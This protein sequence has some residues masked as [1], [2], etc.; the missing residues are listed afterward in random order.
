[1]KKINKVLSFLLILTFLLTGFPSELK[2]FAAPEDI[3]LTVEY[4]PAA[5]KY[6]I[7]YPISTKPARVVVKFHTADNVLVEETF[8]DDMIGFSAGKASISI[9]EKLF[10]EDR[11]EDHIYDISLEAYRRIEDTTPSHK[12]EVYYLAGMTFEGESF[13]QMAKSSYIEDSKPEPVTE[14]GSETGNVVILKSGYKPVIKLTWNVPTVIV[15]GNKKILTDPDTLAALSKNETISTISFHINMAK[16][17]GNRNKVQYEMNFTAE[18][19]QDDDAYKIMVGENEAEVD[20][21]SENNKM[22][23]TLTED[24]GIEPGTEYEFT[25]IGIVFKDADSVEI[26]LNMTKFRANSSNHFPVVNKDNAFIGMSQNPTSI[27]TPIPFEI[28]KIDT[29]KVEVRFR[30]IKYG[31]YPE[32]YYQVQYAPTINDLTDTKGQWVKIPASALPSGDYGYEI[33]NIDVTGNENPN[34]YFRV[35]CYDSSS[36]LPRSSSL[37]VNLKDLGFES[38]RPPMPKE[39]KVIP[40]YGGRAKVTVPPTHLSS[41]EFQIPV[42]NLQI[43][44]EKPISWRQHFNDAAKD[45]TG[46]D[47]FKILDNDDSDY[48]FH[49]ILSS[50]L[51]ESKVEDE[52]KVVQGFSDSNAAISKEVYLPVKQK[53][54]LVLSK[55]DFDQDPDDPNKI[56][57]QIPGDN[58]FYDYASDEELTSE[59]NEDPSKDGTPGDYPTFLVPNT[60]YYMQ[61]F[62]SRYGDLDAINQ[63]VWGDSDKLEGL[64]EKISYMSPI[65]SFTTYPLTEAAVPLPDIG[66]LEPEIIQD[67][68]TGEIQLGIKVDVPRI[69]T[70]A[71]WL[72][73]TDLDKERMVMYEFF[74]SR[75]PEDLDS[76]TTADKYYADIYTSE[77]VGGSVPVSIS[78]II[79]P[80]GTKEPILPNTVYYIKAR[81]SLWVIYGEPDHENPDTGDPKDERLGGSMFTAIKSV[82]MPKIDVGDIDDSERNPRAP[83]SFNIAIDENGEQRVGDAWVYL[84][85]N[86]NEKDVTYE[87][88]CTTV[89]IP[90]YDPDGDEEPVYVNDP[91][92]QNFLKA[93]KEFWIPKSVSRL[94][95]DINDPE[96][97]NLG[98]T[99]DENNLVVM[100]VNKEFLRPNRIYY[101]SLRA[102]RNR[103]KENE[104]ISRWITVPVTTKMVQAPAFL[105]VVKDME[106]GFNI[107]CDVPGTTADSMEVSIKKKDEGST[108]YIKLNRGNYT[109]VQD[110]TT[111]YFRIYNLEPNQWY[112]ILVKNTRNKTWYDANTRSW[113]ASEGTPVQEKTLNPLTEIEVRFEGEE[114]YTYLLEARTENDS[115]YQ[116]LT[117]SKTGNTDYGYDT[118]AGREEFYKEKTRIFVDE[119]S[120]KYIYYARI[121]GISYRDD[122]G[123]L[124][125]YQPLKSNTLYYIK[126]FKRIII[127]D[128]DGGEQNADSLRVGPVTARTDFSQS[129]YDKDKDKDN[130][131]DLFNDTADRLIRKLYWR[132][133]IKTGASVR[134]L[135]K[136]DRIAGLLRA[137]K[138][139]TIT[140]DISGEQADTSY[141]EILIPYKTLEA[142]DTFDSR[143]NI[144]LL[145]AEITINKGSIDLAALKKQVLTG[146]TKE[147]MLLLKVNRRQSPSNALSGGLAA[148]SRS[149]GLQAVAVGSRLSYAEIDEMI[150][151]ILKKPDAKGPFKYGILDRELTKVLKNLESYS[152]KSHVDLKDL[153]NSVINE[154]EVELSRY[155]KDIIDGGSGLPADFVVTKSV[156]EF[157]GKIGVKIEYSYQ[158]GYISPYVNYG[159]GWK[160]PEGGKGYV[161]QYVLFRAE[162]PGEYIVAVKRTS[163]QQPG[164]V[165]DNSALSFLSSRYDLTKVFGNGTIYTANPIKGEQAVMLY[166]VVT[167]RDMEITGL[168]PMQKVTKLDLGGIIGSNEITGYMNNQASVSLAV[169]LYCTKMNIDPKYMRPSK[170][171]TITNSSEI[172]PRLYPYVVLGVDLNLV[173]LNNRRFDANGRTTIGSMLDMVAKVLEGM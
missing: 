1:M 59:N 48:V 83:S 150:F 109:C 126:V 64:E 11:I 29:D 164:T 34:M 166:A 58:L 120:S 19:D 173:S 144:K 32:L 31:T 24:H 115:K 142:I 65:V 153:I 97:Q 81:A 127:S 16:G 28:T 140:V 123:N 107:A 12:G 71:D 67:P 119:G 23:V 6:K 8:T 168:T 50:Y 149:Y 108:S 20:F 66:L 68:D 99:T 133:D 148:A 169:K 27:F 2:I 3:T 7:S 102:V 53:R 139:S 9:D 146:G 131:T 30:K 154:V 160:S 152:Y 128:P 76:K 60:T 44:M 114:L 141:Y 52:T 155:L 158:N 106:I 125:Y 36:E 163:G 92:N 165:P 47:S 56:T 70:N 49:I 5:Y 156:N 95:L 111:F 37:A 147:A 40:V 82:T 45:I 135:L 41:G 73:Y 43:S 4:D 167:E 79:T 101:F 116:E 112:D 46:W 88:V 74:V 85:W 130:T 121:R 75:S 143:L 78:E 51:P 25:N 98:L 151:N 94:H 122:G 17:K 110:G 129:D 132:I 39:I 89:P 54:V 136:D 69:L 171:I 93:Y 104:T 84:S 72:R 90:E 170:T 21:D 15:S 61:M 157:P 42:T 159:S 172:S 134:V 57:A 138:G 18:Y 13:N 145:G 113:K 14:D 38:G 33:V 26:P 117:F 86:H 103:G 124:L 77:T 91:Y 118:P 105:E 55:K 35:V 96:L 22:S 162:K 100:P 62:T 63:E 161:M 87:M 80:N 10:S 137:N